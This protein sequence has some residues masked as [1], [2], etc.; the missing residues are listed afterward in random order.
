MK[1]S[2]QP[3]SSPSIPSGCPTGSPSVQ[4]SIMPSSTK[5]AGAGTVS[6]SLRIAMLGITIEEFVDNAILVFQATIASILRINPQAVSII[7]VTQL[8]PASSNLRVAD[9]TGI[10][11]TWTVAIALPLGNITDSSVVFYNVA[12]II[13]KSI[14]S[15]VFA[16]SLMK[17]DPIIFMHLIVG[18]FIPLGYIFNPVTL[19]PTQ[20]P[21]LARREQFI[22]KKYI[23][24]K[25]LYFI[26]IIV[27]IV[28]VFLGLLFYHNRARASHSN[29]QSLVRVF[30]MRTHETAAI[31]VVQ[32]FTFTNI[33][34][35]V[36]IGD[37]IE[38]DI[39]GEPYFIKRTFRI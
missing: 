25:V 11:V 8:N 7:R 31:D 21:T 32:P 22:D 23:G 35:D 37:V 5:H 9:S 19:T 33:D 15:G 27:G 24:L 18:E 26:V 17:S 38:D 1:P 30:P 6:I 29:R 20:F 3:T 16:A 10:I 13:S 28:V 12:S 34:G 39:G 14:E 4:P 2:S 36:E